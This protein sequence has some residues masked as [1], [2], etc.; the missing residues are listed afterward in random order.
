MHKLIALIIIV[1]IAVPGL[2]QNM[3]TVYYSRTFS[4][5]SDRVEE[6]AYWAHALS[7]HEIESNYPTDGASRTVSR[8]ALQADLSNLPQYS[9]A[10]PL[11]DAT[12][13]L[14]LEELQKDIRPDGAFMAGAQ[15]D[16]VWTRDIS[17]SILLSLAA[18]EPEISKASL[19]RKVK[20]DRIVQ[21]TGTGG[22]WPVSSDRVTWALAAW[23]IYKVTGDHDWLR[24][25]FEIV[26][27]SIADDE[28]VVFSPSTG[29]FRGESSFL[30]W[31]EQTYPQWMNGVDI[32]SAEALGTNV[33]Y[34][35]T[36][37]ILAEM[38]RLL[39]ESAEP[40]ERRAKR[41]R[42]EL[43]RRL[44]IESKGYY[45]QYLYGRVAVT[46]S[47]RSEAL[48]EALSI[49]F[50]VAEPSRQDT[51]LQAVPVMD[52]GIPCVYPQSSN[53][54][55][56]HNRAI[57]PFVQ[58]FWNL[59]AAKRH[60]GTALL[61]GLA[62]LYRGTALFLTNKEN[63]VADTGSPIGTAINSD[64]Q[65]WSVAGN[66]AMVYRVLM[67]MDFEPDGLHLHP[68]IP[69]ALDGVRT[70]K[71]FKYR[72]AVLTIRVEGHG[73]MIRALALDG[74]RWSGPI[75]ADL[76]GSHEVLVRMAGDDLRSMRL[77]VASDSVAP[78][79]PLPTMSA[80]KLTWDPVAGAVEYRV[81]RNGKLAGVTRETAFRLK[82]EKVFREYQVS[83]V[84][85][86]GRESLLSEPVA[87]GGQRI[88]VQAEGAGPAEQ[89]IPKGTGF[90]AL[91]RDP[92]ARLVL[93][94]SIPQA[95]RYTIRFRYSNGSGPINTDNKCAIRTLLID[96]TTSGP[97]VFPQRGVNEWSNWGTS[98]AQN[99][100]LS[101][102]T[103]ELEIRFED[104]DENM[105]E[106]VNRALLDSVTL[107]RTSR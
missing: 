93:K 29:L 79:V 27:N 53:I 80:N 51:I 24:R 38:A 54:P 85:A 13:N 15:W 92:N 57:W 97:I 41:I 23:E 91:E 104:H 40:Y 19:L 52:F 96:G 71:N 39:G 28:Q 7:R 65:L 9:S 18:I 83:T 103:H 90:V 17:Y 69:K 30:D 55:P 14:S 94:V 62:S 60:D 72:N 32:Y 11:A 16:G 75:P 26:R 87:A 10:Y 2:A 61:H 5:W 3:P 35:R 101:R 59:S 106:Q 46:V 44:W 68:V 1:A 95:G 86:S 34:Y 45:G 22:S 64:R 89:Q 100:T 102:G 12:Y 42:Q 73:S 98:S 8:W 105:N 74:Q 66:L 49:L 76:R 56:Y 107:I 70:L 84:D 47:P 88:T 6:G 25:S 50:D 99:V 33:V 77:N 81:Y 82:E 43:N 48:G 36:Y 21:D 37:R 31:R 20:R 67:G 4:V 58:A 63:M 78:D